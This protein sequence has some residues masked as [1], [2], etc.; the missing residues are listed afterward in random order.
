MNL[1]PDRLGLADVVAEYW[2]KRAVRKIRLRD[3]AYVRYAV[4]DLKLMESFLTDFGMARSAGTDDALYMRGTG[5][6][7]FIH[8]SERGAENKFLGCA[9]EVESYSDL[10]EASRNHGGSPIEKLTTPGGGTR[11][12]LNSPSGH[13]ID[14]VFGMTPLAKIDSRPSYQLNVATARPRL[15]QAVR[16][17]AA[18]VPVSRLGHTVLWVPDGAAEADWFCAHFNLTPSDYICIPARPE[19]IAIGAF[20]RYDRGSEFVEHHCLLIN[21]SKHFGCHHSSYEV[22]D[23]DAVCAGHEYLLSKGWKL[24]A[25]VGRHLLGSLIYDYWLDPFGNRIEHYTDTDIIN[26]K[27][28]PTRF[29][30]RA[31]ETTQWGMAPPSSFFD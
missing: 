30:G 11:V 5:S 10:E 17:R 24:D 3:L 14:L 21:Q 16:Q 8:V 29:V 4:P 23:L 9:F 7:H 15:N 28:V 20:L 2:E 27:H 22:A 6:Q 31:D 25:G 13:T 26:D 12:R 18:A 1:V 19:P